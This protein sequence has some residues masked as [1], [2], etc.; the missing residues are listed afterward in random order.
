MTTIPT[1][2]ELKDDILANIQTEFGVTIPAWKKAFLKAFAIVLA[3]VFKMLYLTLG[4]VQKNIFVDT[5]EPDQVERFGRVK[6]NRNRFPAS[7]GRY[8]LTVTGLFGGIIP[9]QTQ[10]LSDDSSQNPGKLFILDTEYTLTATTD[11]IT[12]RALESGTGSRLATG[13]TLTATAP[14]I[15]VDSGAVVAAEVQVPNN[16]ED[17]EAYRKVVIESY[18]LEPQ[19]GAPSDFRIWGKDAAGVQQIYPY[20]ASNQPAEVNVYVEATIGD[21]TDG[22]GTPTSTILSDV[23]AP[24]EADPVTV[25]VRRS[26]GVFQVNTLPVAVTKI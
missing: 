23:A 15:N 6:I 7:Q 26:M 14:I 1:L 3:G 24:I 9:A 11:T 12:V 19:G 16:A 21:S 10:F 22:M 18:Q 17:I 2:Q 25:D 5:A 20:T 8:Q 13:D 4:K